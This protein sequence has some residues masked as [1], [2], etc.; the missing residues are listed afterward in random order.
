MNGRRPAGEEK[1]RDGKSGRDRKPSLLRGLVVIGGALLGRYVA[2]R[3]FDLIW[4]RR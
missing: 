3:V 4:R 1:K 2:G